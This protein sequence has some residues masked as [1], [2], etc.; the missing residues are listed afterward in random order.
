VSV[1]HGDLFDVLPTLSDAS[2][3][4]CVTDPPYELAFMG[5]RWD[6]TGVA[7]KVET[8]REVLRVLK[9]G[10]HL[11]AFGGTRTFHRMT[12]AIEDAG[13]EIRDCLSWLYGS[14]FPKSLDVSKAIDRMG[15]TDGALARIE[16]RALLTNS[17]MS[18]GDVA[19]AVGVSSALVRFW[20]L[21]ERTAQPDELAKLR[22]I[23]G[24]RVVKEAERQVVGEN[25]NIAGRSR[26]SNHIDYGGTHEDA[27]VTA[28]ATDAAK[29][30]QGWGTALKP[31]FE[32]V[33]LARKPKPCDKER[34]IIL[35]NLIKLE[36][37]LWSLL[38][39]S[40]AAEVFKLSL[41]EYDAACAS[42]QWT[43]DERRNTWADLFGQMDMSR[44]VSVMTTCLSTVT[45]WSSTLA[46]CSTDTSTST[47]G[48]ATSQ[49]T[50]WRT[51]KSCLSVLTPST[52]IQAAITRPG[53]WWS[54]V[55]A[56]RI[57]NAVVTNISATRELSALAPVI[58]QVRISYQDADAPNLGPISWEPIILA[59][60]PTIGTVAAN[61]ERFGT[62]ALNIDGCRLS[63]LEDTP[64]SWAAKGAGGRDS[65]HLGQKSQAMRDAY[66][67]GAL[68]L[69]SGRW[70]ANVVLDDA[71]AV[72]LDEQSGELA[73]G[74]S[75]ADTQRGQVFVHGGRHD[76][77]GDPGGASRFYYV[78]KPSREER[79][80]GCFDLAVNSGGE[81]TN[82][83]DGSVGLN[84][85]RAG[86]GR[87]GGSRNIHPT[88]KPVE[89]MRWLVRLVTPPGG[90]VLDPFTG[91]GTTGMACRYELREFVGIEREAEYVAIAERRI[92]A[93]A[94]LFSTD[95]VA[96]DDAP[97]SG[98][99]QESL[100]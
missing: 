43:A 3:D 9:P 10:A 15:G 30:W 29:Q 36:A 31:S 72:L 35:A 78:A 39:A 95:A 24:A 93:V 17:G 100:L 86:S 21:G 83:K 26:R 51:L 71:A 54:A 37:Q 57:F 19:A 18:D 84:N 4:A 73:A 99:I 97:I 42:A 44:C 13:F 2:I 5:K 81:A 92:A 20:R 8:W 69:P 87:N 67:S 63:A 27:S 47:T 53:S 33:I 56:A 96:G 64:E 79:D 7:F 34:D 48:T 70:P 46:E 77:Y 49:T 55:P 40:T 25:R 59:R 58:E 80:Y 22:H 45:S 98:E 1:R 60:K 85:P 68:P 66:R 28:P 41:R 16:L 94:P 6:N 50:D 65:E 32:P 89:L 82:R 12:S 76:S 75:R 88:V 74:G 14:G 62:A 38:P 52:I 61:V 90:T 91:S 11:V 23:V